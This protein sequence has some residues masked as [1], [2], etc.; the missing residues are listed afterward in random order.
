MTSPQPAPREHVARQRSSPTAMAFLLGVPLAVGILLLIHEGPLQGSEIQHYVHHPVECVEV[1]LFCVA[2]GALVSKVAGSWGE[3]AALR[4]EVLPPYGGATMSVGEAGPLSA[5][6]RRLGR[7]LQRTYLVRRV[8]GVLDFVRSRGSA[9]ELDDQLRSLTDTDALALEGSYSLVR[10]ITW[11]IPILG[12]LGT[13]LGI[14]GAISGVTPEKLE[15]SMSQVTD[16]LSVAFDATA[17]ALALTMLLMFLTFLVERQEQGVLEAVD[18]YADEELAH[19]FER[20]GA[21]GGEFVEVVRQN[22]QVL[23]KATEQLA[24]KQAA[25]W[26]RALAEAEKRWVGAGQEQQERLT[27][28]LEGALDVTLASHARRLTEM[29]KGAA[30]RSA[31][32]LEQIAELAASVRD[33]ARQQ[34]ALLTPLVEKLAVQAEML[35]GLQDGERHLLGLHEVLTQNLANVTKLRR[36]AVEGLL[37]PFDP[38]GERRAKAG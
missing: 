17:L 7:G 11:A 6:L 32:L 24:E 23:V 25:V 8:A 21:E 2:F 13:V 14:T 12:F 22:T 38:Q 30:D 4:T 10:L 31:G 37:A 27:A 33:S 28:A 34:Q 19:R 20:T 15:K 18:R 26:A 3:R 36:Q 16:G 1:I 35:A 5:R 9:N 29:E